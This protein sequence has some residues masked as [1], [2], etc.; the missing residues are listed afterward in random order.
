MSDDGDAAPAPGDGTLVEAA[1]G[2]LLRFTDHGAEVL[3][4]HRPRY[5]DWTLPK[6]KLDAGEDPRAGAVRELREETGVTAAVAHL[7]SEVRYRDGQHRPKRVRWYRM[8]LLA[9]DPATRVADAE[10]DVA[11]WVPTDEAARLLTYASER[12]VLDHALAEPDP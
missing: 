6:G 10:V 9:G 2:V 3:V 11:R 5:D 8:A 4:V 12:A 7:L 1:G